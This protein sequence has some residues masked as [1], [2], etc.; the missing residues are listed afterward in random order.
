MWAMLT[1]FCQDD[2]RF[3]IRAMESDAATTSPTAQ[4]TL[5]QIT[6]AILQRFA[7]LTP[8]LAEH[9]YRFIFSIEGAA[10]SHSIFQR[11]WHSRSSL[12]GQSS[13]PANMKKDDV[14]AEWEARKSA[15]DAKS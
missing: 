7:P 6:T 4:K 12:I 9:F 14:K 13:Q 1:N 15:Y 3:Y 10:N 11:N 5:S 2:L 8:F